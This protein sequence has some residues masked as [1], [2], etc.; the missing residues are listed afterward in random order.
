MDV[1]LVTRASGIRTGTTSAF[2]MAPAGGSTFKHLQRH[3]EIYSL[4]REIMGVANREWVLVVGWLQGVRTDPA[5]TSGLSLYLLF[6]FTPAARAHEGRHAALILTAL[7]QASPQ[8][9]TLPIL[10]PFLP[11]PTP[12]SGVLSGSF[13][14]WLPSVGGRPISNPNVWSDFVHRQAGGSHFP[15]PITGTYNTLPSATR[16]ENDP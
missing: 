12:S 5:F 1:L 9:G 6:F 13:S 14:A 16:Q 4:Q 15:R 7:L 11:V 2:L 8:R 3:S 10:R